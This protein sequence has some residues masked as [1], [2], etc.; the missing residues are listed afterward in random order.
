MKQK[1]MA[2]SFLYP[3]QLFGFRNILSGISYMSTAV[4][5][6]RFL[7]MT[8]IIITVIVINYIEIRLHVK[9]TFNALNWT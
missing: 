8:P 9:R 4:Q 1:N 3:I 7:H 6:L 2:T 5:L